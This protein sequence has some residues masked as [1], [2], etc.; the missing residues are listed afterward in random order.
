MGAAAK[1]AEEWSISHSG[2]VDLPSPTNSGV[3][4]INSISLQNLGHLFSVSQP[5]HLP[6]GLT[7]HQPAS[8]THPHDCHQHCVFGD[9]FILTRAPQ[10]R[11][12]GCCYLPLYIWVTPAMGMLGQWI[13]KMNMASR[14][15]TVQSKHNLMIPEQRSLNL[16]TRNPPRNVPPP[17]AGTTR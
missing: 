10:H 16:F 8:P 6:V 4:S 11:Q 1:A 12:S 17:P 9:P 3:S 13:K 15:D 7:R 5:Q 14:L 2:A